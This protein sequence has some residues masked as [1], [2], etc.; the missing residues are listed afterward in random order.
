MTLHK[1]QHMT[2]KLALNKTEYGRKCHR[3]L[4]TG[5]YRDPLFEILGAN[6]QRKLKLAR[7]FVTPMLSVHGSNSRKSQKE[8]S[9]PKFE[10]RR[11]L[12]DRCGRCVGECGSSKMI[13]LPRRIMAACFH[14]F[15]PPN[16]IK[17]C[18]FCTLNTKPNSNTSAQRGLIGPF[19]YNEQCLL[20]SLCVLIA[21]G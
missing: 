10:L 20:I 13:L 11:N 19:H 1:P 17:T 16:A 4:S 21:T 9:S 18:S 12:R 5:G 8:G 7:D 3:Y 6:I 15:F 2:I 14:H